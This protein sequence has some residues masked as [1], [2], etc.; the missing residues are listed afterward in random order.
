[1]RLDHYGL[2][3]REKVREPEHEKANLGDSAADTCRA[4]VLGLRKKDGQ[5]I[6]NGSNPYIPFLTEK[7]MLRHPDLYGVKDWDEKDFTND[8]LVPLLLA[9]YLSSSEYL[10]FKRFR[11][12]A[13]DWCIFIRGTWKLLQPA[14]YAIL[15]EQWWLLKL[16]NDFQGFLLS[17][18]FRWSDDER[19]RGLSS[20]EGKVQDYLNMIVISYFLYEIGHSVSLPRPAEECAKAVDLYRHGV[21]DF[22]PNAEWEVALYWKALDELHQAIEAKGKK[23]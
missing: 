11:I 5:E 23:V 17:L 7:G 13:V 12:L 1:M 21:E 4:Y 10:K 16:F 19:N 8:Q 14:V 6:A 9:A 3:V 18:P 22:E 15:Y 20:S 2:L